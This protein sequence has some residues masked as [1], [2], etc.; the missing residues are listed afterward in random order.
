MNYR[1]K[2]SCGCEDLIAF[3]RSAAAWS[4]R[5]AYLKKIP[6][7]KCHQKRLEEK[8]SKGVPSLTELCFGADNLKKEGV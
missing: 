5:E 2:R 6:C 3:T 1:V 7:N 8:V 4:E